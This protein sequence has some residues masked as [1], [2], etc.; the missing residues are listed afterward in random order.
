MSDITQQYPAPD[1]AV[2]PPSTW[3]PP[4]GPAFAGQQQPEASTKKMGKGKKIGL[5][6]GGIVVALIAIG[7]MGNDPK[8]APTAAPAVSSS[9]AG[10]ASQ[11]A[12][13]AAPAA[14]TPDTAAAENAAADKATADK[15]AADKAAADKAAADKASAAKKAD[16]AKKAAVAKAAAAKAA[17]AKAAAAKAAAAK[18]AAEAA[19]NAMTVSQE[20][21][22]AQAESYLEFTAFSRKGLIKQLEFE[23]F[24]K[25]DA[26]YAVDHIT[27]NWNE[28]AAKQ[29]RSYLD[30]TAFSHG[31]LLRQLKFEGFTSSQAAFGVK[32]VGL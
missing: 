5:W 7:S 12:T 16:D 1:G 29:A 15:A 9:P 32:S 13:S 31:S 8:T 22:V 21:A 6:T 2:P 19:A 14:T 10:V 25:A 4:Q 24:S 17:A 30:M 3:A 27:V 18:A 28:Q 23:E 26:T 20:Q 11:S